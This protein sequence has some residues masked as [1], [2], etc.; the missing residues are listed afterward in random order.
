MIVLELFITKGFTVFRERLH[1][2]YPYTRD[3]SSRK[4]PLI[5]LNPPFLREMSYCVLMIFQ[6]RCLPPLFS[7]PM[8]LRKSAWTFR[9]GEVS[10]SA[11][12][13]SR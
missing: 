9:F 5:N 3:S 7:L 4:C 6:M 8:P 12:T 2:R 1:I 10:S 13:Y 11:G